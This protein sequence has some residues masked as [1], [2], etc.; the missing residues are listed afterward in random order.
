MKKDNNE[1]IN[2]QNNDTPQDAIMNKVNQTFDE[3]VQD[4]KNI[5]NENDQG[6]NIK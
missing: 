4:V 5:I 2:F 3:M 6:S 1:S